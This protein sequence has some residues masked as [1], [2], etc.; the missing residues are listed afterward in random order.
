MAEKETPDEHATDKGELRRDI[1][2]DPAF[3][4]I[5]AN[6]LEVRRTQYDL[7]IRLLRIEDLSPEGARLTAM[8]D[9]ILSLPAAKSLAT[10][11]TRHVKK[12]EE[13]FGCS[14]PTFIKPQEDGEE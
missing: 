11:L 7:R 14:I 6:G 12:Y 13:D 3:V 4:S 10:L 9:A 2:L 1:V 8:A 5:Y